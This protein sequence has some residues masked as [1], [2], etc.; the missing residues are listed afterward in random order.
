MDLS[1][2]NLDNQAGGRKQCHRPVEDCKYQ[3]QGIYERWDSKIG[4]EDGSKG[5]DMERMKATCVESK[6]Y[7]N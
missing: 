6:R 5:K 2:L 4:F 3:G 7:G 1:E